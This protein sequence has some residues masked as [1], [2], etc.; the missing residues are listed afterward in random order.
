MG[1]PDEYDGFLHYHNMDATTD[2]ILLDASDLTLSGQV[3]SAVCEEVPRCVAFNNKGFLKTFPH[4]ETVDTYISRTSCGE[5]GKANV[6]SGSCLHPQSQFVHCHDDR[7]N[8]DTWYGVKA[9]YNLPP[10]LVAE[11]CRIDNRCSGFMVSQ[12]RQWG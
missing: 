2:E 1:I 3:W 5:H 4:N 9:R 10:N 8:M 6:T 12:D 11:A 7:G